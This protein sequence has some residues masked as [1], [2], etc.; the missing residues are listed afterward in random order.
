MPNIGTATIDFTHKIVTRK[1][2]TQIGSVI[3]L[4]SA[5]EDDSWKYRYYNSLAEAL[6]KENEVENGFLSI[7]GKELSKETPVALYNITT[8]DGSEFDYNFSTQKLEEAFDN[9]Q[10]SSYEI[11]CIPYSLTDTELLMYNKFFID[12]LKNDMEPIGLTFPRDAGND[13]LSYT[14]L[15]E[16][17]K[18]G[19][20]Y[21]VI[22]TPMIFED[23]TS[24]DLAE[25]TVYHSCRTSMTP[26]EV[27]ETEKVI[28]GLKGIN[29]R[30]EYGFERFNEITHNGAVAVDILMNNNTQMGI[31][32]CNTPTMIDLS[33][34]RTF[35]WI[36][37][38]IKSKLR[39]G[40]KATATLSNVLEGVNLV[41]TN[42]V[43]TGKADSVIPKVYRK[44]K[45]K[46]GNPVTNLMGCDIH[47]SIEDIIF[48]YDVDAILEVV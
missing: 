30:E 35:N 6:N 28:T 7:L 1:K 10:R 3:C 8:N 46:E 36:I 21:K 15:P 14:T 42:A 9:M 22:T 48:K 47:I 37:R 19:G 32:N 25:S 12:R 2:S 40:D 24:Y 17:F 23:G 38:E 43:D 31:V 13:N 26:V 18:E 5:F 34:L 29:T 4:V 33:I 39:F 44:D 11:L 20:I 45:D 41:G 27:S 16:M